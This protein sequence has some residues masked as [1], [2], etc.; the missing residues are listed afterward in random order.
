MSELHTVIETD[1]FVRRAKKVGLSEQEI[2]LIKFVVANNPSAGNVV[3]G[4]GGARKVR[5]PA[6]GRGKSGGYRVIT[7]YTGV[8]IPVFLLN[9]YSKGSK[10][11]LTQQEKN[12]FRNTISTILRDY[13]GKRYE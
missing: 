5:I 7:F 2:D 9:V 13:G 1:E 6:R 3:P 11:D 12:A 4:T 10:S 8:D